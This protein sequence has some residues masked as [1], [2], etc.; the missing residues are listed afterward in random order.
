MLLRIVLALLAIAIAAAFGQTP[1]PVRAGD[2][3]P[4]LIWTRILAGGDPGSLLG[5]VTVIQF[6]AP[7]SENEEAVSRWNRLIAR[8]AGQPVR[9]VWIC[10]EYE[11][12]PD[13]WL[14]QH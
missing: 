2:R 1:P 7:V 13:P 4:N 5:H 8:F 3:A 12:P 9:F 6:L 11:P 14:A 10:S